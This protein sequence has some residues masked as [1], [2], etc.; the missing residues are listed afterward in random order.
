MDP[1]AIPQETN[2]LSTTPSR[3]GLPKLA[4]FSLGPAAASRDRP[5]RLARASEG[6]QEEEAYATKSSPR[7]R[8]LWTDS[9][10][11]GVLTDGDETA[12][13]L[14]RASIGGRRVTMFQD[15]VRIAQERQVD[16]ERVRAPNADIR[17]DIFSLAC[18]MSYISASF[19][20]VPLTPPPV[21]RTPPR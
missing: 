17:S 18:T 13:P 3:R 14:S 11:I 4:R 15:I 12:P 8:R 20:H 19:P 21:P 2:T 5:P 1:V 10:P 9:T 7:Q 16:A 6:Y